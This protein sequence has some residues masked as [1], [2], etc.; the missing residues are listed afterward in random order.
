[1]RMRRGCSRKHVRAIK[2]QEP[3]G[4]DSEGE[5]GHVLYMWSRGSS[6]CFGDKH[7]SAYCCQSAVPVPYLL[8][9]SM[10]CRETVQRFLRH[11]CVS[12]TVKC[13]SDSYFKDNG[14]MN[15]FI[16]LA[17]TLQLGKFRFGRRGVLSRVDVTAWQDVVKTCQSKDNVHGRFF[18]FSLSKGRVIN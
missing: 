7:N 5:R 4:R 6:K 16:A 1:M 3:G 14:I 9:W 15:Y 8:L 10:V 13:H 18:A 11:R 17:Y 12:V 2:Q